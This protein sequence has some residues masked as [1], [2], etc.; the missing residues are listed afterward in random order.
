MERF[1]NGSEVVRHGAV[2]GVVRN[3]SGWRCA[4]CGKAV[5]DPESERRYAE[6]ASDDLFDQIERA[7]WGE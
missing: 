7:K 4:N 6:A 2:S 3:L 1:E 5:L